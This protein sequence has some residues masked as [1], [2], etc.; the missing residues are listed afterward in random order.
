MNLA[1]NEI[2]ALLRDIDNE[3]I[4]KSEWITRSDAQKLKQMHHTKSPCCIKIIDMLVEKGFLGMQASDYGFSLLEL[5]NAFLGGLNGKSGTWL[6]MQTQLGGAD[7]KRYAPRMYDDIMK[8][9][10]ISGQR[11][12]ES[13]LF[14]DWPEPP[15]G[16]E[17]CEVYYHT[18]ELLMKVTDEVIEKIKH[19]IENGLAF[20]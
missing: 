4:D 11:I 7:P 18:F 14:D 6:F 3:A 10:K 2:K 8:R 5:R 13:A 9:V 19:D 16:A 15:L 1:E 20:E 17:V 12:I